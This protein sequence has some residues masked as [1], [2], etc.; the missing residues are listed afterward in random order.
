MYKNQSV[1]LVCKPRLLREILVR[2]IAK[3]TALE[4]IKQIK[5]L[6]DLPDMLEHQSVDWVIF[7]IYPTQSVPP[8]LDAMIASHP[9]TR[10]I[11]L[12]A[13]GAH[14]KIRWLEPHEYDLDDANLAEL[15]MIFSRP[16]DHE[17]YRQ[18]GHL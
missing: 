10:F 6:D 7:S 11:I 3:T 14:F 15:A 18:P 1:I 17:N 2:A 16:L 13:D 5:D 4:I 12:N 8:S 9:S